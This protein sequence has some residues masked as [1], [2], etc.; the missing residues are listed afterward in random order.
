MITDRRRPRPSRLAGGGYLAEAAI[1]AA[2]TA[3]GLGA[4]F[5]SREVHGTVHH[6]GDLL[7]PGS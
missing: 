3:A 2:L 1:T 7:Q 6:G 5:S 4:G